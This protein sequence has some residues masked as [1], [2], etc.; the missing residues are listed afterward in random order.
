[1]V[2]LVIEH[3]KLKTLFIN[4]LP[5]KT[6]I[7]CPIKF[8]PKNAQINFTFPSGKISVLAKYSPPYFEQFESD[9]EYF[10]VNQQLIKCL[11]YGFRTWETVTFWT[12]SQFAHIEG[13]K[14]DDIVKMRVLP[15]KEDMKKL[16]FQSIMTDEGLMPTLNGKVLSVNVQA[17]VAVERLKVPKEK[18]TII[19]DWDEENLTMLTIDPRGNRQRNL[20]P[21]EYSVQGEPITACFEQK[22]FHTLINQFSGEVWLGIAKN[23]L[24]I[25]QVCSDYSLTYLFVAERVELYEQ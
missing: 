1:M 14:C 24:V 2:K 13:G 17:K 20:N 5:L 21:K 15:V 8:T 6:Q 16:A 3:P 25:S 22:T 4:A 19:L 7:V 10:V 23:G 18:G 11:D 9:D 12:E